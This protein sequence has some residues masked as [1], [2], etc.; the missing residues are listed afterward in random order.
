MVI[1]VT[2]F[3]GF[4]TFNF[5]A[6]VPYVSVTKNGMTF[7]KSVV[8]KLD[9]P[10]YVILLINFTDKQ[11]AIQ[12]CDKSVPNSTTFYK[13]RRNPNIISVRWNGKDLLNTLQQMMDWDLEK[14]AFRINGTFIENE[15]AMLFDLNDAKLL[16]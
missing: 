5:D 16:T 10:E 7:N 12:C 1:W 4:T 15:S 13:K 9:Y 6:G 8:V 2:I 14:D 11:I 3:E